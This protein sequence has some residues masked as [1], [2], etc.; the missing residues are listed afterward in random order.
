MY[1]SFNSPTLLFYFKNSVC[2]TESR[3]QRS[4]ITMTLRRIHWQVYPFI[5][6]TS[7]RYSGSIFWCI[8]L[9][10][11]SGASL[12]YNILVYHFNTIFWCITLI[13]YSGVSLWYNILAHHFD[14]IFWCIVLIQYSG[15]S[16]WYNIL[17]YH[18]DTREKR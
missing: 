4:W 11:Y 18:F 14:T 10:Q 7:W 9:I 1:K 13:Q 3:G 8:T 15:A 6:I 12:W 16:L 2:P 17:V 5:R